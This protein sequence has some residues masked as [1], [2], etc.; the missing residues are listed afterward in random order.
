M[1]FLSVSIVLAICSIGTPGALA[2]EIPED[3]KTLSPYFFVN[4]DDPDIDALPLKSTSAQVDIAGVIADVK[5]KQVYKN[6]GRKA[7]EA[8]YIFPG[9]TRAAVYGMKMTI[10]ERTIVANIEKR[11]EARQQY[12]E[13]KQ[14]GK[15]ASLLEQQRPNVFQ[16]NVA[17]IMPGDEI[18]VEMSYTELLVPT[19]GLYEFVYPTVVGPRYSNQPASGAPATENWVENPYLREGEAPPY[20]FDIQLNLSTGL[21]IQQASCSSHKVDIDY[22]SKS[23]AAIKLDESEKSGGNRDFILKYQ[24]AGGKVESGLLLFEGVLSSAPSQDGNTENF[25]LLM[26]QPPKRVKTEQIPPREYIFIVDVSGSMR[27]FPLEIS[28]K[29]LKDLIG[30]LQPHEKFNVLLFASSSAVLSKRGSLSATQKNIHKAIQFLDRRQGGGG[31]EILP[32]LQRALALPREEGMS[33]TIVIATDGYVH[34]ETQTFDLIRNKLGEANMFAFGIGTGVNRFLIEGMARMGMGEPFILT[35]PA[36]A[37]AQAEKFRQYIQSPVL[38]GL[39][40]DIQGFDAYDIEPPTIPDVLA[41]R[42]VIISGK[43]RGKARGT[44]TLSG[45]SN[46]RQYMQTFKLGEFS[47]KAENS[48][49]RYLWARHRIKVLGDYNLLQPD[50]ERIDTIAELGLRYNLLTQ[51]TSFVAIDSEIRNTEGDSTSVK[52]PLPL[53][54][55]VSDMAV[56]QGARLQQSAAPTA[57]MRATAPSRG[58]TIAGDVKNGRAVE[59]DAPEPITE[60]EGEERKQDKQKRA[61]K[62]AG[63]KTFFLHDGIWYDT[64]Y[65]PQAKVV[66]IKRDSQAYRDLLQAIPELQAYFEIGK[67]VVVQIGEYAIELT[68]DGKAKLTEQE[69]Q[70]LVQAFR[71]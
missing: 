54:Q 67:L 8:I 57:K 29:L 13:A 59:L 62:T 49:L 3:D 43:W 39:T 25:F 27:G 35:D 18:V 31:T 40:L 64:Q 5:V 71:K 36:Q 65:T 16:M 11:E 26:A 12:E 68:D 63:S 37:P 56:G 23:F 53:P 19:D 41:E 48:A 7:L 33:R 17:N 34:V 70:K 51:Y 28:K 47:S 61:V 45:V 46:D 60:E 69:L 38:T 4:S 20:S 42:P 1:K 15:S 50:D 66:K 6:E 55:G 24:L 30:K 44:M 2:Q 10:G 58:L 21:P 14:A 22:E 9:S 52:Q 32:A